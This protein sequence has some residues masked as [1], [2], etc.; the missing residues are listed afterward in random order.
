MK[1]KIVISMLLIGV[2]F[3][4]IPSVFARNYTASTK[5]PEAFSGKTTTSDV[6]TISTTNYGY[7]RGDRTYF[8]ITSDKGWL[9][10]GVCVADS[11]RTGTIK[12]YEDDVY[13]NADDLVKTYTLT[14]NGRELNKVTLSHT[15]QATAIDSG[16]DPT[17][18]LY[19]TLYI[20][21]IAGDTAAT[22]GELY[23]YQYAVD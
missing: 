17:V 16:T 9:R 20:S 13:P 19:H 12:M 22:N 1:K 21:P 10:D 14:F 5:G 15:N 6:L 23:N 2:C 7:V 4:L 18:E 3:A 8:I 11:N